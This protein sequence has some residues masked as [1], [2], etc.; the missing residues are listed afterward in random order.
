MCVFLALVTSTSAADYSEGS[1]ERLAPSLSFI[2]AHFF[3]R[4]LVEAYSVNKPFLLLIRQLQLVDE[5]ANVLANVFV[6]KVIVRP[7][8]YTSLTK[9][10][11][12]E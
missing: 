2:L 8:Q 5:R 12:H 4:T 3:K 9:L 7:F 10:A 11:Q 6:P 1:V